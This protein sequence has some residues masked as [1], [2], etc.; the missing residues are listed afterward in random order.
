MRVFRLEA[1]FS[2]T[3]SGFDRRLRSGS[4][5]LV[6]RLVRVRHAPLQAFDLAGVVARMQ[7][8][9]LAPLRGGQR[10][11]HGIV[12]Q[13]PAASEAFFALANRLIHRHDIVLNSG[14]E[15]FRRSALRNGAGGSQT[16]RGKIFEPQNYEGIY[17][18]LQSRLSGGDFSRLQTEIKRG[19]GGAVG[20]PEMFHDFSSTPLF[21]GMPLEL[22]RSDSGYG[23]RDG[24]LQLPHVEIH[25]AQALGIE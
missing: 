10:S 1:E 11:Q 23:G 14:P 2:S 4:Q 6:H 18:H 19:G 24:L 12:H 25:G 7:P 22:L 21:L 17:P 13:A 16:S 20:K 8:M 9:E 15:Q 5:R 3:L